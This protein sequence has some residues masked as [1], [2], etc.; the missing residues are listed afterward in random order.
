MMS[1]IEE[2]RTFIELLEHDRVVLIGHGMGGFLAWHLVDKY[3]NLI[4]KFISLATPHPQTFQARMNKSW[5][6]MKKHR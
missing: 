3:P 1:I 4:E 5:A 6:C 2:L